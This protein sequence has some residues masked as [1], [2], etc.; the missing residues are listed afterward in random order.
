LREVIDLAK[1]TFPKSIKIV[2]HL[3]SDMWPVMGDPT[4]LHQV[5]LNLCI[6]ARDAMAQGGELAITAANRAL[7]VDDNAMLVDAHPGNYL[8]VEVRDTGTG[9]PHDLLERIW[10]PFFTTKGLGK[11]TGLGLSTVRGIVR[12]HEGFVTVQTLPGELA[13]HGTAFTVYV[14]AAI[15][16]R[17][18][19]GKADSQ[20]ESARMGKGELILLVDDE[21]SVREVSARILIRQGYR[22]VTANDGAAAIAVFGPRADEVR[23]LL[24]DNDMPTVGG[25]ALIVALRR[26]NPGLPV[27]IMSGMDDRDED[28]KKTPSTAYLAKPFTAETLMSIVRRTLDE[29]RPSAPCLAEA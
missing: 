4:E 10:E 15:V 17:K 11:G 3:P 7:D 13:G 1:T 27:V 22:V 8:T 23:L 14:P 6:N 28:G 18:V 2:S 20:G 19:A 25:A 16:G 9:I 26:Q 21:E 5:F 29:A 12:Q 24:T